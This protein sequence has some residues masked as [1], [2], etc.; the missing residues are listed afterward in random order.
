MYLMRRFTAVLIILIFAGVPAVALAGMEVAPSRAAWPH[1]ETV[2]YQAYMEH[3]YEK[4]IRIWRQLADQGNDKGMSA[5]ASLY[6]FGVHRE[7]DLVRALKWSGL[8]VWHS[9]WPSVG[10]RDAIAKQMTS[11]QIAEAQRLAREW[12]REHPKK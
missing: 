4:A 5:L 2:A 10:F 9:K 1:F 8:S 11:A 7:R 6:F 3:D 12:M